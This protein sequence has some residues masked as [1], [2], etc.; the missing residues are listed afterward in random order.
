MRNAIL[1]LLIAACG[2]EY[3]S[4]PQAYQCETSEDCP[5]GVAC[6]QERCVFP[7][8]DIDVN[9]TIQFPDGGNESEAE[10]CS[11]ASLLGEICD[12]PDNDR[13][14]DGIYV[15]NADLTDVVCNDVLT[16][17]QHIE[18]C[19]GKDQDCDDVIDNPPD[20]GEGFVYCGGDVG[21]C[22]DAT[23]VCAGDASWECN[24]PPTHSNTELCDG[25]DNNCN[26]ETDE[27]CTATEGESESESESE[28]E[29]EGEELG[30]MGET[31]VSN[32]NCEADLGCAFF[33][34]DTVYCTIV[35]CG[36]EQ[37]CPED[38]MCASFPFLD[39][40]VPSGDSCT[41]EVLTPEGTRWVSGA[42]EF[43]L[44][45]A[46][47]SGGVVPGLIEVAR[48]NLEVAGCS[49]IQ[50]P[51]FEFRVVFTDNAESG[52]AG[53][54]MRFLFT[55]QEGVLRTLT[56]PGIENELGEMVYEYRLS[57]PDGWFG[58]GNNTLRIELNTTGA[59]PALDDT[60]RVDLVSTEEDLLEFI[61]TDDGFVWELAPDRIMGNTLVF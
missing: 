19:D 32:D 50:I 40:C 36:E 54:V 1:C 23:L 6:I 49:A 25:L 55:N 60:V 31:C 33:N 44:H 24:F 51:R 57:S 34:E 13:C 11:N 7:P 27:D 39:L 43:T 20:P 35:N 16:E 4:Y 8:Q 15:C 61:T 26:G 28:A 30:G 45:P 12:G 18:T 22:T 53:N 9:I 5:T 14:E 58:V 48:F 47:P 41:T 37:E 21:V 29:S 59:S 56:A 2:D 46:S 10:P 42:P 3:Y 17:N 38:W 52:W